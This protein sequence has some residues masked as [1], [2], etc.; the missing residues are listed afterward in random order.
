MPLQRT[1][2]LS[3]HPLNRLQPLLFSTRRM[4]RMMI[5]T[6]KRFQNVVDRDDLP[7]AGDLPQGGA[8]REEVSRRRQ[9]DFGGFGQPARFD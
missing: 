6:A 7:G 9:W 1:D 2:W 4:P 8:R 3:S 5:E